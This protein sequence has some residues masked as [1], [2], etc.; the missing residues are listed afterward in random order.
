MFASFTS[1]RQRFQQNFGKPLPWATALTSLSVFL[2][3]FISPPAISASR[4]SALSG[5][6]MIQYHAFRRKVNIVFE[7]LTMATEHERQAMMNWDTWIYL[8]RELSFEKA[9]Y[10]SRLW[11]DS[12]HSVQ[13]LSAQYCGQALGIPSRQVRANRVTLICASIISH[14]TMQ[15]SEHRICTTSMSSPSSSYHPL[16]PPYEL[17]TTFP[18]KK[19]GALSE[20]FLTSAMTTPA[21]SEAKAFL[22]L[23]SLSHSRMACTQ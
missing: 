5:K 2:G 12:G 23:S 17:P 9:E 20:K 8:M 13:S 4:C 1:F 15:S 10:S 11:L 6:W 18:L 22:E 16:L 3:Y 14:S 19:V 21:A 7:R